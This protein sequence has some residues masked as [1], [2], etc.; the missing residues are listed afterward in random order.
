MTTDDRFQHGDGTSDDR[1]SRRDRSAT[2]IKDVLKILFRRK[3]V[4]LVA[5]LATTGLAA[6]GAYLRAP[7]FAASATF[8]VHRDRPPT[9]S[10]DARPPWAMN[11]EEVIQTEIAI[12]KSEA[13][14]GDVVERLGLVDREK[15]VRGLAATLRGMRGGLDRAGLTWE[16]G[17][18]DKW[19]A[20]IRR[21]LDVQPLVQSDVVRVSLTGADRELVTEVLDA[22]SRAYLDAHAELYRNQGVYEFYEGQVEQAR[23]SLE[24]LRAQE[25]QLRAS[26]SVSSL[27]EQRSLLL[28]RRTQTEREI[29]DVEA[30]R[31]EMLDAARTVRSSTAGPGESAPIAVP[32]EFRALQ[33]LQARLIDLQNQYLSRLQTYRDDDPKVVALGS[34]IATVRDNLAAGLD[35]AAAQLATRAGSLRTRMGRIDDDLLGLTRNQSSLREIGLAVAAA[36]K[37][38]IQYKERLENARLNAVGDRQLVNVSIID[39]ARTP[40]HPSQARLEVIAVAFAFS[41][42]LGLGAAIALHLVDPSLHTP[43]DAQRRLGLTVLASVPLEPRRRRRVAITFKRSA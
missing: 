17:P 28:N 42:L 21:S 29:Q 22:L 34:Q 25:Q 41:L 32:D 35:D 5:V 14:L 3:W 26:T 23:A 13:V 8:L 15:P 10:G 20:W 2:S 6:V 9:L 43:Q 16:V 39:A 37:T 24:D 27:D 7:E 30:R 33:S 40:D 18:R 19:M 36:E 31:E 11:R 12:M 38:Y 4:I 1:V